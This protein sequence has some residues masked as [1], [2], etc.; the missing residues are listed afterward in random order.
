MKE[1]ESKL[2]EECEEMYPIIHT[3][4][5]LEAELNHVRRELGLAT[6]DLQSLRQSAFMMRDVSM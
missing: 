3:L 2:E 4:D 5:R 1:R 6:T